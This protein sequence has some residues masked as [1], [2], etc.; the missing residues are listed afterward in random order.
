MFRPCEKNGLA[1]RF[2]PASPGVS[3]WGGGLSTQL[4]VQQAVRVL[5]LGSLAVGFL[6]PA[7][8]FLLTAELMSFDMP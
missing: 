6:S 4:A 2:C 8:G 3:L 5:H 7:G 1:F